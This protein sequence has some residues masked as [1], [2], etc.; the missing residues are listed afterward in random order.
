MKI[1]E[2]PEIKCMWY[3]YILEC[4]KGQ[5][6]TGIT[7]DVNRRLGEHVSGKGGHYTRCNRPNGIL[8]QE[9]FEDRLKAEKRERQIKRWSKAK[10]LALIEGELNKL[11]ELSKSRD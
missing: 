10:K 4:N 11:T 1:W 6:Y 5:L 9:F 8:Y 3:L 2:R 7:Q